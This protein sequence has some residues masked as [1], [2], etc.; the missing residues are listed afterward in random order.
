MFHKAL[1]NEGVEVLHIQ[2]HMV[3]TL[4]LDGDK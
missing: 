4:A 1:Y 2:L 3:L